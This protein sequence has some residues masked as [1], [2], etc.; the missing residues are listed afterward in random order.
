MKQYK[1]YLSP[2]SRGIGLVELM[3]VVAMLTGITIGILAM[4]QYGIIASVK[5]REQ[6]SA[7]RLAQMVFSK[8]KSVDFY[9]L[10]NYDSALTNY[11][12]SGTYGPVTSQTSTY[13]YLAVL[14]QIKSVIKTAGF[15]RWTVENTFMRR[16]LS[17]AN[18]NGLTSDLIN[19]I[20]N[21]SDLKDDYL[22]SLVLYYNKNADGDYYD[23]YVL[24]SRKI[25]EQPDT[26]IKYVTLKIY[27][28]GG[29]I[30]QESQL[31]SYELYTGIESQAS[32][33]ALKLFVTQ[34]ANN[35]TLYNLNT[36][37]R[38]NA[39]NLAITKSYPEDVI[40]YRADSVNP[41]RLWGETDPSAVVHFYLN[42]PV[43]ELDSR[44]ADVYGGFDFQSNAVTN[45]LI[46]GGN[47]IL[48]MATKDALYSPYAP[49]DVVLDLNP[50]T[51]SSQTPTGTV[52]D[53][54]PY[55][56]CMLLD[57]ILSTGI[58]SC[59]CED[60]ICMKN[61]SI[62]I[63]SQYN[64]ASGELVWIDSTTNISPILS[65][66][67]Y[68]MTAEG[69]D[70]AYYKVKST[71]TFTVDIQDPD[72]SAPEVPPGQ[73][74]PRDG[75]TTPLATPEIKCIV[76]DQQSGINPASIIFTVDSVVVLHTYNNQTNYVSWTPSEPYT[77]GS[78]HTVEISVSHWATTP[79]DK[80]TTTRSWNFM[81]SY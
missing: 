7:G 9:Y 80:V 73:E 39:F 34:P 45:A 26:H 67:T 76:R 59:I 17:D 75:A 68:T 56:G 51:I 11:G 5:A 28:K 60:V 81:V 64:S 43:T 29:L 61:G 19:F 52:N 71:W 46:E 25:A 41:I 58:P 44:T 4:L 47:T 15:D 30:H 6:M 50:P 48:A 53:R 78:F 27:K 31:I 77:N 69:G 16:D 21:N 35:T 66:G 33:A 62:E 1:H 37:A 10:F 65:T 22:P 74:D 70:N 8:L 12:L 14:N 54:M 3:L 63:Y 40:A 55:V 24:N 2:A 72:N 49:R 79:S 18:G 38:Q 32:D 20:D 36:T 23:S 13:P 57:T 42:T